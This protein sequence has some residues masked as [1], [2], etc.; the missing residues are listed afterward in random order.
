ME[1]LLSVG[2]PLFDL[3]KFP[4]LDRLDSAAREAKQVASFYGSPGL[5]IGASA[6]KERV[7][8]EMETSDVIHLATHAI[9]D[10]WNPLRS[11]LLLAKDASGTG[12][13]GAVRAVEIYKLN[14]SR[15]KLVVLSAC[16]TGVEKYY[17]GEGMVGLSR[18]F[19]AK[20]IPLV[21]A[22][23]WPVNSESTAD[24]MISFQSYRKRDGLPTVEALRKAQIQM[25]NDTKNGN[26]LPYYWASFVT[27]GGD[28]DF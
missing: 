5:L 24:L 1:R 28:A 6:T 13:D 17:G 7:M 21:V 19:I 27:I 4:Y 10:E 18:P 12:S 23:L 9:T 3:Q 20:R 2:D 25:I 8:S 15:A 26:H 22:S 11:K 16:R 14:L